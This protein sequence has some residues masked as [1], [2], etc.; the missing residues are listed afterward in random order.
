MLIHRYFGLED[1]TVWDA[2]V[3]SIPALIAQLE[4]LLVAQRPPTAATD[5]Q[6]APA[7]QSL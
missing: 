6:N 1:E 4:R 5:A 3:H 7:D 2:V